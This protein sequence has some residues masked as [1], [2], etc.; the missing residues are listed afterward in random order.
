FLRFRGQLLLAAGQIENVNRGLAFR[1]DESDLDVALVRAERKRDLAQQA[2]KVLRDHLQKRGMTRGLVVEFQLRR[3]LYLEIGGMIQ[4]AARVQ[5]LLHRELLR[6]H[7]MEV[8]E[9][10][11]LLAGVKFDGPEYIG[12][13]EAVDD[14]TGIVGIRSGAHNVHAPR[15]QNSGYVGKQARAVAGNHGQVEELPVGPQVQLH[16]VLIEIQGHLEV[17]AN[18][19]G[20][21][22]LQIA[23][24]QSFQE[25][26]QRV[27]LPW[28]NHR[29]DAI[30]QRGIDRG[31]VARFVHRAIHEVRCGHVELPQ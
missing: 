25:L 12:E 23:L 31:V 15:R 20:Q 29:T 27:V 4:V 6:Y 24:R 2:R 5:Q 1:V 19:L 8:G 3:H 14:D 10:A 22:G 16:R 13:M 18:L 21:A 7:V 30:K 11:F 28:L 17:V 9:E 26:L